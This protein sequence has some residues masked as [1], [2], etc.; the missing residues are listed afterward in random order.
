MRNMIQLLEE[1]H[2]N[3]VICKACGMCWEGSFMGN[4]W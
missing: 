1:F 3:W 4:S 2:E